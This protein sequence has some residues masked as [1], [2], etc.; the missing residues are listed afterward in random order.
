[1]RVNLSKAFVVDI[2]ATCWQSKEEQ[3]AQ[4]N[5]IIEI[6]VA[7]FDFKADKVVDSASIMVKPRFTKVSQFCTDLTGW[8]QADVDGGFD[9]VDA[10]N[11]FQKKFKPTAEHLWFSCGDYDRNML[12]TYSRKGIGQLY[13]IHTRA[14]PFEDMRHLNIKTLFALKHRLNREV[15]MGGML[16]MI[17]EK[18]EGRHHNGCDDAVNIAK[19]VRHVFKK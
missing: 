7:V 11:D 8:A 10:L 15:G 6:G 3:G 2:E 12:S 19:I 4:P 14:N 9:I 18:I 1:M 17:G 13:N 5:E 16:D